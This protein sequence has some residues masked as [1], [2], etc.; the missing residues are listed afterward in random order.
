[1]V[2]GYSSVRG[3]VGF[4]FRFF[5]FRRYIRY[6]RSSWSILEIYGYW[7][8]RGGYIFFIF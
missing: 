3:R 5:W 4:E 6:G 1:M 2:Y 7:S 8:R